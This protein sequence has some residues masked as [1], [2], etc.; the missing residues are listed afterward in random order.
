MY[1]YRIVTDDLGVLVFGRPFGAR[2]VRALGVVDGKPLL[3]TYNVDAGAWSR[4]ETDLSPALAVQILERMQSTFAE[5][6]PK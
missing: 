2:L 5:A 3:A 6:F 4:G 1:T